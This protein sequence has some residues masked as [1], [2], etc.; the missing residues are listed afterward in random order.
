MAFTSIARTYANVN[1]DAPKSYW[2]Y[3]TLPPFASLPFPVRE[4]DDVDNLQ[5]TW[6]YVLCPPLGLC[7]LI[8]SAISVGIRVNDT[9]TP[10]ITRL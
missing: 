9:G 7:C 4:A 10:T 3:G 1:R 5:V 6:G 8:L 2:D